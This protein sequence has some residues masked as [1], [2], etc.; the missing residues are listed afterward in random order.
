MTAGTALHRTKVPLQVWVYAMWLL[1]RR[2]KSIS[3]LQLQRETGIGSYRTAWALLHKVRKVL[4]ENDDYPLTD[5]IEADESS[6]A[7][8]STASWK[9]EAFVTQQFGEEN[10]GVVLQTEVGAYTQPLVGT[11]GSYYVVQVLGREERE[12]GSVLL[13]AAD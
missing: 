9:T 1:G 12:L 7:Y 4:S 6:S 10:G 13:S 8:A 5:E 11:D 3:A 2:K